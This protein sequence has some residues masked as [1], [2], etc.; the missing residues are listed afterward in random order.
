MKK[1]YL[2]SAIM[3]STAVL[4]AQTLESDNFDALTNGD[5]GTSTTFGAPGQGGIY[6]NGGAN[7][8]YQIVDVDAAHG[9]SFQMS[10]GNTAVAG[11]NR[12][13]VKPGLG[14]AWTARTPGN[15]ILQGKYEIYT[16][17]AT[18]AT[19]L[20]GF[21]Q[22]STAGIVGI[23]YNSATQTL[24]GH[25]SLTPAAGGAAG[26]YTITGLTANT[27]P[28]NTWI[29]VAFTYDPVNGVIT[30]TIDGVKSTLNIANFNITKNLIPSQHNLVNQVIATPA[31]T[32]VNTGAIDNYSVSAENAA[33]LGTGV[34][35]NANA[36]LSLYPNP[37]SDY[38]N[39]SAKVKT[40]QIFDAA[41]RNVSSAKA[42]NN[43]VDVR[44]L[45]KGA[46]IVKFET[47]NGTQTQ[48]FIKK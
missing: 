40:V 47:E 12:Q 31:N 9:K 36:K 28:A 30:Y 38:L 43:Q 35:V 8:D 39:F 18:G 22:S 24:N 13:A 27:Y 34:Y 10:S 23:H 3:F 42:V 7:S 15:D 44:N 17:T 19:R 11:S 41:G 6:T 45:A 4:T 29:S 37:T 2:F 33:T 25:A 46:Y 20:G 1:F 5:V 48:K 16:G 14:T 21:V 32:V 26:F